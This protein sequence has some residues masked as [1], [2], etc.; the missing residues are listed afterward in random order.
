MILKQ[1]AKKT[2]FS[3]D[4]VPISM[5]RFGNTSSSSIPITIVDKYGDDEEES[6]VIN[7]LC[8]G[9]GVGLSWSTVALEL[10]VKD[11]LPLIHTDEYFKDGFNLDDQE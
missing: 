2:G 6:R 7:E 9:F 8:C 3:P 4:K 5:D 1:I 10:N 11:V